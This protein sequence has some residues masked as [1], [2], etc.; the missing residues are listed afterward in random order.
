MVD[1]GGGGQIDFVVQSIQ[2]N[3]DTPIPYTDM[4]ARSTNTAQNRLSP[5]DLGVLRLQVG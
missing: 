2:M 3:M 1:W 5:A 4:N